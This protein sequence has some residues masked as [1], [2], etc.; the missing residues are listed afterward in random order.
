MEIYTRTGDKGKTSLFNGTRVYKN[1]IRVESYGTIDELNS[2]V[3]VCISFLAR[4]KSI[5]KS[6]KT[7]IQTVNQF[8]TTLM[9]KIKKE[10]KEIQND[11]FDIGAILANPSIEPSSDLMTHWTKRVNEFEFLIDSLTTQ[12]PVLTNFI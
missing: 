12:L 4:D 2:I 7:Q 1:N 6:D 8:D 9:D 10:L 5:K 3:G 11:L